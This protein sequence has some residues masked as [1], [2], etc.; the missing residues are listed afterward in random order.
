VT[1]DRLVEIV[2]TL[3]NYWF[4]IV[5]LPVGDASHA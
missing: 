3:G 1:F 4:R 2:R 5:E